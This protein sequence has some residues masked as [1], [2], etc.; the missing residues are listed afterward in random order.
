MLLHR[1]TSGHY[2]SL[3]RFRASDEGISRAR[4]LIFVCAVFAWIR[5]LHKSL[6]YLF[7]S[8]YIGKMTVSANLRNSP[9]N[10]HT[11]CAGTCQN[12]GSRNS[13]AS[14]AMF[15]LTKVGRQQRPQ[16]SVRSQ[17]PAL[18]ALCLAGPPL[19][20]PEASS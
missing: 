20:R 3:S 2:I 5:C 18:D 12:P 7:G 4:T 15:C 1:I 16:V 17:P 10:F 19:Q 11:N 14:E 6:Q 13:L 8:F 9:Q